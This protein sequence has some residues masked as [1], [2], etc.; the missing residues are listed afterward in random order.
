MLSLANTLVALGQVLQSLRQPPS[1][2]CGANKSAV[3]CGQPRW[4]ALHDFS[5]IETVFD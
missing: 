5:Y 2:H 3:G 1:L 4:R